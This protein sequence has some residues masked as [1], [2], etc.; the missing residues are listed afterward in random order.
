[1]RQIW[2]PTHGSAGVLEIREAPDPTPGPGEVAVDVRAAGINFADLLARMGLYPDAPPLPCV[3][4]YEGSGLV[5]AVGEGVDDLRIGDRVICMTRFGGYADRVVAPRA[6][7]V[8]MPEGMSFEAGA[9]VPVN[10]LTAWLMLREL[11]NVQAHHTVLV[12]AAAGGVGQAA[13]QICKDAGATVIGTA[14]GGKHERLRDAGCDHCIDYRTQ[15]YAEQTRRMT[16]GKG[17]DIVLDALGGRSFRTGYDLLR[18]MGRLF[19]F[20]VSSFAAG[21]T[22]SLF[23]AA[24]GLAQM[25][26][27]KPVALMNDNRGVFGVNLGHLWAEIDRLQPMLQAIVARIEAG[28]F[29]P[30]VDRSFSFDEAAGAHQYIQDRKNFGKVVLCP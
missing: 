15:D 8:P 4:G 1:M 12:H 3:V 26:R 7:V 27:F 2:I 17:V 16:D 29:N 9:A 24:V 21:D 23:R 20:G 11:G 30:V 22:R 10:Y 28:A 25:P 14:S 5:T 18:P 13:L 6:Q 19:M